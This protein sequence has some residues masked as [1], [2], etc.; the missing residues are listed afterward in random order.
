MIYPLTPPVEMPSMKYFCAMKKTTSAGVIA[1]TDMAR[2]WFQSKAS[3][4]SM[5]S[6]SARETGN[7][8]T[9]DR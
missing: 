7:L 5:D 8:S 6:F 3:V 9:E 4:V 2:I 1:S